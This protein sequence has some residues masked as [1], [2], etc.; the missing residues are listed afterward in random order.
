MLAFHNPIRYKHYLVL[1][2]PLAVLGGFVIAQWI[3]DFGWWILDLKNSRPHISHPK[4]QITVLVGSILLLGLYAWQIPAALRL[5]EAKAAIPQPPTDEVEALTFIE[6]VTAPGDCLISDDTP[7]LYWSGRMAPPEL[8]E[9]STNRLVSGALTTAELIT[10]SDRYDCQLVAAVS[11]RITQYLPDYMD[12][13]KR[14]YLGRFHYGEDDLYFA[15]V[16]TDP[17]P[18]TP[19]WADFAGQFIFHG[20]TL[21]TSTFPSPEGVTPGDRVALTLIWQAQTRP[22]SDYAIFVQLR[23]AT[24]KHLANAD[25]QPYKGLVPTSTWPAGAVIQTVTWLQLPE[26]IPPGHYNIYVGL[27]RP[28]NS[29]ERLR[30]VGD[31]SGENALIL[32]PL[33]VQ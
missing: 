12:W 22:D 20:Y 14:T 10:I 21:H 32:G 33:V 9:V 6:A 11:N 13:V 18:A 19:L 7:L 16:D 31:T 23:D 26:D 1:I 3:F 27:Y 28:D 24:N 30:L 8:A 2:P 17:Q 5:W 15:K 25:F 4:S 29:G